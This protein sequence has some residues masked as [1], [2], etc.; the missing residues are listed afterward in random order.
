MNTGGTIYYQWYVWKETNADQTI[1]DT[2]GGGSLPADANGY[3]K[4]DGSGNL[5]W[6]N[7]STIKTFL[8]LNN[9]ENTALSTWAGSANLTTL[10]TVATGT[11]NATALGVGYG[12]TGQTSFADGELLIG[13]SSGNTLTKA[14]LTAGSNV[15]ITNAG[16]SITIDAA[17]GGGSLPADAAGWLENDGGG[18]LSWST[19]AGSLPPDA[20]GV[21]TN[22]GAGTVIWQLMGSSTTT[23]TSGS[24]T[25]WTPC[26]PFSGLDVLFVIGWLFSFVLFVFVAFVKTKKL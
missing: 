15:T 5:S 26:Q 1:T 7:A 20:P 12:G 16:G 21:L 3:L 23:C 8:S 6:D 17:G 9:V 10:G 2:V 4:N 24:G 19:P 11:W 22:D 13:N 18:N 14:T 25:T